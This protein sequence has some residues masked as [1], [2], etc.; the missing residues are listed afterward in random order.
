VAVLAFSAPW[1]RLDYGFIVRH[2]R[3]LPPAAE[4]FMRIVREIEAELEQRE[5][6]LRVRFA[7]RMENGCH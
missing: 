4:E 5:A 1:F 6:A 3:T 2:R 7:T